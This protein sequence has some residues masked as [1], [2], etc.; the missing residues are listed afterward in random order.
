MYYTRS[1][2]LEMSSMLISAIDNEVAKAETSL[3]NIL[4]TWW[5]NSLF[6]DSYSI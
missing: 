3:L 2:S 1:N 4:G 6:S 5:N